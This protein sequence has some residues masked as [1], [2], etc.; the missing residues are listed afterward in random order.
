[1][2]LLKLSL[3][4][5]CFNE[6]GSIKL[7]YEAICPVLDVLSN[8]SAELLFIDDGS[9]DHTLSYIQRFA[10]IDPRV[11]YLSFSRNFGK[12]AAIYAG[13]IYAA[14]D[15][16]GLLDA[17]LQHPPEA[18]INMVHALEEGYDIA[19]ARRIDRSG[20]KR[21]YSHCA[22]QFYRLIH[23]LFQVDIVDGAQDF[24]VLK[25]KV[26]NAILNMPEYNRFSKG[27]FSW[28]GFKIKWFD[29]E[30]VNRVAGTTKWSFKKSFSYAID[31]IVSFTTMPLK[32]SFFFGGTASL[33]GFFYVLYLF[34]RTIIYG[35]DLPGFP[36]IVSLIL[37]MCGII[38]ISLGIVGEYIGKIYMEVKARPIYIVDESNLGV[39]S[40]EKDFNDLYQKN[41]SIAR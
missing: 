5:P 18:I 37:I 27:I 21:F 40:N 16:I 17:D 28:V 29:H 35:V 22:R 36:T 31:G 14:G 15:Y 3:I 30:N 8:Y 38:L 26:V 11:K 10:M 41:K 24:R 1:M 4:I 34:L 19:A 6:E 2:I 13:F 33:C 25:R 12:E 32:I 9:T 23:H 20:E 7:L 39:N